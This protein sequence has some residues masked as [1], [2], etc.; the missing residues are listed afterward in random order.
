MTRIRSQELTVTRRWAIIKVVVF[1]NSLNTV[2]CTIFS[3]LMS[4]PAV[5][6]SSINTFVSLRRALAR[7][8]N[9]LSPVDKLSA[10]K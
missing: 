5:A 6:S 2:L 3:V 8:N 1:F 9:C 7:H 4:K 10:L